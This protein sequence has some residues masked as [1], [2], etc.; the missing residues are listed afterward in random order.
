MPSMPAD[1]PFPTPNAAPATVVAPFA[2]LRRGTAAMR[3]IRTA[4]TPARSPITVVPPFAAQ[5]TGAQRFGVYRAMEAFSPSYV[6]LYRT[7]G[8]GTTETGPDNLTTPVSRTPF[9]APMRSVSYAL[10]RASL[11]PAS[12]TMPAARFTS[13]TAPGTVSPA[14]RPVPGSIAGHAFATAARAVV[15]ESRPPVPAVVPVFSPVVRPV[16]AAHRLGEAARAQTGQRATAQRTERFVPELTFPAIPAPVSSPSG[17]PTDGRVPATPNAPGLSF[18]AVMSP[19]AMS[20]SGASAVSGTSRVSRAAFTPVLPAAKL[21]AAGT[22]TAIAARTLER[23]ETPDVPAP[24]RPSVPQALWRRAAPHPPPPVE[25]VSTTAA[26]VMRSV[27]PQLLAAPLFTRP[28]AATADV[29]ARTSASQESR[30]SVSSPVPS[31]T[32]SMTVL[33]AFVSRVTAPTPTPPSPLRRSVAMTTVPAL[34]LLSAAS[35]LSP[36]QAARARE[37]PAPTLPQRAQSPAL[38]RRETPMRSAASAAPPAAAFIP[39]VS[40]FP[41]ATSPAVEA[42]SVSP[43]AVRRAALPYR[44][45]AAV[46]QTVPTVSLRPSER[47][48]IT[49]LRI[50]FPS[51]S[52]PVLPLSRTPESPFLTAAQSAAAPTV[53]A[54]PT[55]SRAEMSVG[56]AGATAP[57]TKTQLARTTALSTTTSALS[58]PALPTGPSVFRSMTASATSASLPP[59]SVVGAPT[60]RA[61]EIPS[62]VARLAAPGSI[63]SA[64][65]APTT[66]RLFRATV[67]IPT[68]SHSGVAVNPGVLPFSVPAGVVAARSIAPASL[69]PV[70]LSSML[71]PRPALR[72]P[73]MALPFVP[74]TGGAGDTVTRQVEVPAMPGHLALPMRS[75]LF[76]PISMPNSPIPTPSPL[77]RMTVAAS[78]VFPARSVGI[79]APVPPEIAAHER[80]ENNTGTVG[81][82]GGVFRLPNE[83]PSGAMSAPARGAAEEIAR[84]LRTG[85]LTSATLLRQTEPAPGTVSRDAGPAIAT[86]PAPSASGDGLGGGAKEGESGDLMALER[87]VDALWDRFMQRLRIEQERSGFH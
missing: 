17:P 16:T 34:A 81:T 68:L 4:P 64:D 47:T 70:T 63:R 13:S 44:S 15:P 48:L 62:A 21:S 79:A 53:L 83:V 82:V 19:S 58:I 86:A 80:R 11:P 73:D 22:A 39:T 76:A 32:P 29:S 67:P 49:A 61:A 50:P 38:M 75:P 3:T 46:H 42:R 87:Q 54:L 51:A 1:H 52:S 66:A 2:T 56:I 57:P 65:A 74:T 45:G 41:A 77:R 43:V 59:L 5:I 84:T 31:A 71:S 20:V 25:R 12:P 30:S 55:V 23:T 10:P 24:G 18:R 85:T 72:L 8:A 28:A 14:S 7:T 27:V 6:R 37:R 60:F 35:S 40:R 78:P 33:P 36:T 69:A 26:P 9:S